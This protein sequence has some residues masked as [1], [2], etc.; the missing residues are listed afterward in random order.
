MSGYCCTQGVC[1]YGVWVSSKHQCKHLDKENDMGQ[2]KC[3]IKKDIE[4]AEEMSG[5][6]YSMFG[7]GCSSLLFNSAREKVK[8]QIKQKGDSMKCSICGKERKIMF[9]GDEG[10]NPEPVKPYSAGTCCHDC[11]YEHVIP[12]RGIPYDLAMELKEL[13]EQRLDVYNTTHANDVIVA[14]DPGDENG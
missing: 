13:D 8:E 6:L 1:S 3:L 4:E 9:P 7:F 10:H 14:R 11:E 2:R 5:E 12:A